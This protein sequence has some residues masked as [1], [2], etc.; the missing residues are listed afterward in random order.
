MDIKK[1]LEEMNRNMVHL[2]IKEK[3][4]YICG[5]TRF[6]GAPD[7]PQDFV[8]P[9]F[10]V[11]AYSDNEIKVRPLSFIAQ[12]NC[13]EISVLDKEGLLPQTG[14]LS[15]F[16]EMDSQLWGFDPK[17]MGCARVY[18]FEQIPSLTAAKFPVDLPEE[19]CFPQL[20]MKASSEKSLP[21]FEDVFL[22]RERVYLERF[23]DFDLFDHTRKE[24]GY[25]T[26]ENASK[27]L[28]WPDVIQ[29]N[30][31]KE[32]E[33]ISRGYYLGDGWKDIPQCDLYE[34]AKTSIED[35]RLLFQLDTVKYEDF[36]LMFGDCGRLF[37]Y[38]RKEDLVA[39]RFDRVWL[40]LQCS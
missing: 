39:R 15:F 33:L 21:S 34:S 38:I 30:M 9:T 13:A 5:A 31:T 11:K 16:Y 28:G 19:F 1:E 20:K 6:G 10:E 2:S 3:A 37:F 40:I 36:E 8:W 22:G 17:D 26:P 23:G 24:L 25:T 18:W 35:W 14:V 7:V 29:N 32:C 27:L 4:D 12:F